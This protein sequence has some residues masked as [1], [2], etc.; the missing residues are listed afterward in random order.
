MKTITDDLSGFFAQGGWTF[1][2]A[3]TDAEGGGEGGDE[4]SDAE[5]DDYDPDEEESE[6][7]GTSAHT[8]T[9]RC[10]VSSHFVI[11]GSESEYSG[12]EEEED[13]DEDESASSKPDWFARGEM[14][15]A[16][17]LSDASDN[18][19]SDE[20]SGKSWSELEEEARKGKCCR[21]CRDVLCRRCALD[22][23]S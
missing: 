2:E 18:L 6:E 1:L 10:T 11:V 5:E 9:R 3:D 15:S 17:C 21:A 14:A 7:E 13:L 12:E 16:R 4:D 8:H 23:C 19:G 20:E 22:R